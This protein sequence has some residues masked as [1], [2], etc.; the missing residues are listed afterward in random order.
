MAWEDLAAVPLEV[1]TGFQE[2]HIV[3]DIPEQNTS[4]GLPGTMPQLT[5]VRS[6]A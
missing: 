4:G 2:D 5:I 3:V 6:D 1:V